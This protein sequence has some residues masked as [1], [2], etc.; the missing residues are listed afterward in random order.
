MRCPKP[1][2]KNL[3]V[4]VRET[5]SS[6]TTPITYRVYGCTTCG[7]LFNT[8]EKHTD[9]DYIP[10]EARNRGYVRQPT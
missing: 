3:K 6:L 7:L 4:N 9:D 1:S 5:R 8:Q 2:C 10:L